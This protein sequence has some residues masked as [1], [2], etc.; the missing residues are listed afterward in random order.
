MLQELFIGD[1]AKG[2][3]TAQKLTGMTGMKSKDMDKAFA[4]AGGGLGLA[5]QG[6]Q[7]GQMISAFDLQDLKGQAS[8]PS[9]R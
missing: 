5:A 6:M 7:F 2:L 9:V 1:I 8:G 4:V 3:G